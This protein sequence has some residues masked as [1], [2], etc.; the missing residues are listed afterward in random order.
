MAPDRSHA[1][2]AGRRAGGRFARARRAAR[3]NAALAAAWLALPLVAAP[4]PPGPV[5]LAAA[6]PPARAQT[7]ASAAAVVFAVGTSTYDTG[8]L[9]ALLP[10]FEAGSGLE[11]KVLSV[12]TGQALALA[13]RGEADLTLTHDP[14]AE[15]AFM[16]R[17]AGILRRRLMFN[18]FVIVGPGEDP[19]GVRRAPDSRAA[20]AAI[21]RAS[22]PFV[23]RGDDSGTHVAETALWEAA[24]AGRPRGEAYLE[25]GQGQAATLRIA[26]QKRAY[27]LS[28]RGTFLTQHEGLDL[29]VLFDGGPAW[30][31]VYHL[32]VASPRNGPRV[33][34][35]GAIALARY[36]LSPATLE[37]VR[38]FGRER[39]GRPLF[40]PD[41]EAF[42]GD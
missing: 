31:N 20:F 2:R 19:A 4:P 11:V 15:E 29:E 28:D 35:E 32:I 37:R 22:A 25:T 6:A 41:A 33:N 3:R 7:G 39:Y 18:D 34:V 40:V 9:D 16:K 17:E 21:A 36:L 23:S 24:G 8:L 42:G 5:L 30:S 38:G 14:R 13:E 1:A 12:G 10:A 27:A 26:S